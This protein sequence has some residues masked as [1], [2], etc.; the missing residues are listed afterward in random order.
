MEIWDGYNADRT[1]AGVDIVRDGEFPAGLYHI[2]GETIVRHADG[3]FLVMRRDLN[4]VGWPGAWEIGAGGSVLKGETAYD[5]ALRELY[6]ETG[7][8]AETLKLLEIVSEVH[9]NGVGVHYYIYLCDTDMDKSAVRLQ[10]GETID[11]RWISRD[12]LLTGDY[13]VERVRDIVRRY[14]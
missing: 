2:V 9:E 7:V 5:G 13:I 10:A 11:Y 4:K 8:K 3:T 6:E 14:L 1:K 12:D